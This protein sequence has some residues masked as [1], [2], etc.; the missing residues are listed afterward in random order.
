MKADEYNNYTYTVYLR[1]SDTMCKEV[2]NTCHGE[3]IQLYF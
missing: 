2:Q 3:E 1:D